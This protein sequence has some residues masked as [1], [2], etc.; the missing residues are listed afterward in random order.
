MRIRRLLADARL[1]PAPRRGGPSWREF[2]KSQAAGINACEF[3]TFETILLHRF[4][5]LYFIAHSTPASG[6]PAA[7]AIRPARG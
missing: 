6:L 4:Y 1:E 2:P 5:V 7:R 3:F